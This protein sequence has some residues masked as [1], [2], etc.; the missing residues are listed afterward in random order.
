MKACRQGPSLLPTQCLLIVYGYDLYNSAA[1]GF[2]EAPKDYAIKTNFTQTASTGPLLLIFIQL[3]T[4]KNLQVLYCSV[5]QNQ[6]TLQNKI[7][8]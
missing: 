8:C 6:E 7:E 1:L 3:K 2:L 4:F 5:P